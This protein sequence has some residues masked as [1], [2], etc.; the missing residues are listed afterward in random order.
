MKFTKIE[1]ISNVAVIAIA[2]SISQSAIAQNADFGQMF[3]QMFRKAL[4]NSTP[5][6]SAQEPPSNRN[7]TST[8]ESNRPQVLAGSKAYSDKLSQYETQVPALHVTPEGYATFRKLNVEF[9][10]LTADTR[11]VSAMAGDDELLRRSNKVADIF[12]KR[13]QEFKSLEKTSRENESLKA[14]KSRAPLV[15]KYRSQIEKLGF[16]SSFLDS[17]IYLQEANQKPRK[18]IKFKE[19]LAVLYDTGKYKLLQHITVKRNE[20][21]LLKE[22]GEPSKGIVFRKDADELYASYFADSSDEAVEIDEASQ[23]SVSMYLLRTIAVEN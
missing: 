20:G 3:G 6:D 12:I 4:E 1:N 19:W 15:A 5:I 10:E 21:I 9:L 23:G 8:L 22:E 11:Y 17:T 16:T 14:E 18:F 2:F 7:S 13:R